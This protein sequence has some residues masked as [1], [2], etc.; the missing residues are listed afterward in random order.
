MAADIAAAAPEQHDP[1][2]VQ[3]TAGEDRLIGRLAGRLSTTVL[4]VLV[5]LA[6]LPVAV[7]LDMRNLSEQALRDQAD[8]LTSMINSIRDYYAT[9]VVARVLTDGAKTQVLPNYAAVPGAIPIPA[10]LSL[11]LGDVI[12]REHGNVGFRF[13]SDYPFRNRAPHTFDAFEREALETLRRDPSARLHQTSGSIFDRRVRLIT[14]I[15]MAASCV[16]C[17]NAHVDSPKRDWKVGEVRGIEEISVSQPISARIFA[18][19]Y[20]LIYFAIVAAIGLAF[21]ALQRYQSALIT[22]FNKKLEGAN[23]FL[24]S[25]TKK[26][27]RYLPPQLYRGILSGQMDVAIATERK[28]LTIFFSDVVNFTSVTERMQPEELTTLLN[29]YLTEMSSIAAAH[30]GTVNKFIGDGIVIFFGH[31]ESRGIAEDAKACLAMAFDMQHRLSELNTEW[32]GRG[33]EEPFRARDRHQYRLLQCR[34]FRQRR[35]DGLHDHRRR[36]EPG[37]P[38]AIDRAARRDRAELRDLHAG[39]RS[40]AG[41]PARTGD[42]QRHPASDRAL[43][44]RRRVRR[45]GWRREGDQRAQRRA[46][47]VHRPGH[48]GRGRAAARLQTAR[49]RARRPEGPRLRERRR[50][51]QNS[52]GDPIAGHFRCP[53]AKLRG[54]SIGAQPNRPWQCLYFLPEP[55]GQTSLRPTLPQVV[56]SFGLRSTA[57][58]RAVAVAGQRRDQRSVRHRHLVLAGDR[59][60]LCASM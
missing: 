11:E 19:K 33:I 53:R 23:A 12:N 44:G 59:I 5:I 55:H 43:R 30:G 9:N 27:A 40:R 20:L 28:K 52:C 16:N 15:I 34:K 24:S 41:P 13:F 26:I 37:G 45:R 51:D 56:G 60:D 57:R 49:G 35:A 39:A 32:R 25:V 47:S 29:E 48:D 8:D 18:F 6:G 21:I 31:P 1:L 54:N 46:R 14:P 17:H 50:P 36:G 3:P 2:A 10:T 42:A 38:A 58:T 22:K 4:L 7:W